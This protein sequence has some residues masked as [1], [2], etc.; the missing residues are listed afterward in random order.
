[1]TLSK[2][3]PTLDKATFIYTWAH[4]KPNPIQNIYLSLSTKRPES[5]TERCRMQ[6]A[7]VS[8]VNYHPIPIVRLLNNNFFMNLPTNLI[9]IIS[10]WKIIVIWWL[11]ATQIYYTY[12]STRLQQINL[13]NMYNSRTKFGNITNR[14]TIFGKT[15]FNVLKNKR[16]NNSKTIPQGPK[17][18]SFWENFQ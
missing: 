13:L 11:Q 4:P 15:R 1:M 7:D 10:S 14:L 16:G 2:K 3:H 18:Q 5:K 12:I 8:K 9:F 6:H 17:N